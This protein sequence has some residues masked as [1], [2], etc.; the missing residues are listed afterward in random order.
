M[1]AHTHGNIP[2]YRDR[3]FIAAFLDYE[4]WKRFE[5]PGEMPLTV[6][7]NDII[8]RSA[9]QEDAFY[10]KPAD[11]RYALMER[12]MTD[13]TAVY[14]IDD[15]GVAMRAWHIC[16]TLKANMGSYRDRVPIIKD[17]YGIRKLTPAECLALQGFPAAFAFPDILPNEQ[18]KQLGN[19]VCVPVTERI[20]R[21][22]V[23]TLNPPLPTR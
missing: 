1:G 12:R 11:K 23:E 6:S 4:Q 9:R 15:S 5:F 7:V 18:Y 19:T 22:L 21:G 14:R 20:A 17:N 8:D 2:Q 13:D 10:Y 3:V 16:P